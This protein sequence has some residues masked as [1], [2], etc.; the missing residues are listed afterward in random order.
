MPSPPSD[1]VEQP[2][3]AA[4]EIE[5]RNPWLRVQKCQDACGGSLARMHKPV[6]G[7][8]FQFS[9]ANAP[10]R[11]ESDWTSACRR[12]PGVCQRLP[13]QR[14]CWLR[15]AADGA[16]AARGLPAWMTRVSKSLEFVVMDAAG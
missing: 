2:A 10:A 13:T 6:R 1:L 14:W 4:V 9:D 7:H 12:A 11:H 3:G 16:V 8:R 5:R 15:S